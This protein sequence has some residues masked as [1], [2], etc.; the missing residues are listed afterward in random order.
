[1]SRMIRKQIYIEP[2]Q[3]ACLKR[4]AQELGV[5]E[6]ELIRRGIDLIVGEPAESD[7]QAAWDAIVAFIEQQRD[8]V[9]ERTAARRAM[10]AMMEERA[11]LDVPQTGRS[12]KRDEL[13]DERLA[14]Y[15]PRHQRP[16]LRS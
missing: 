10:L 5:S 16:V 6:A 15:G 13:Y 14:R 9:D 7:S 4:R 11:K 3:D 8:D 12:W 1:M 2:R